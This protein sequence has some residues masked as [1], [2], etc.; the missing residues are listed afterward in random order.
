MTA[1]QSGINI[2]PIG[3][4]SQPDDAELF[5]MAQR[6]DVVMKVQSFGALLETDFIEDVSVE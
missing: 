4:G 1:K 6:E 5:A 2:I 3:I